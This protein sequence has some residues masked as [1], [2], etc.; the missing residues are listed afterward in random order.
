MLVAPGRCTLAENATRAAS[1]PVA[2]A[3]R[4][5]RFDRASV[6]LRSGG[7]NHV[8]HLVAHAGRGPQQRA[9]RSLRAPC[10]S[11]CSCAGHRVGLTQGVPASAQRRGAH[12]RTDRGAGRADGRILLRLGSHRQHSVPR[13]DARR[14]LVGVS[15]ALGRQARRALR[16]RSHPKP[17]GAHAHPLIARPTARGRSCSSG[18]SPSRSRSVPTV[19]AA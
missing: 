9:V 1:Y 13:R 2:L 6:R 10:S 16:S 12:A 19:P 3:D 18:R 8:R 5:W 4:S 7:P 17:H 14:G 15:A 11:G